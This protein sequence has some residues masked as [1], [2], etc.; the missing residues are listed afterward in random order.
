MRARCQNREGRSR[1][2]FSLGNPDDG[3]STFSNRRFRSAGVAPFR[4]WNINL[5]TLTEIEANR[6]HNCRETRVPTVEPNVNRFW[7]RIRQSR[8]GCKGKL[9]WENTT[10]KRYDYGLSR[11]RSDPQVP[12]VERCFPRSRSKD[13]WC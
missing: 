13:I 3:H 7:Q 10:G 9:R 5:S 11:A 4:D 6:C 12:V 1:S 8:K 2:S